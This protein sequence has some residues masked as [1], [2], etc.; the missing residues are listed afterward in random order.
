LEKKLYL[1][2]SKTFEKYSPFQKVKAM[3]IKKFQKQVEK[4]QE[5]KKNNG[6]ES[7]NGT[8]KPN[9]MSCCQKEGHQLG[10]QKFWK[11]NFLNSSTKCIYNIG[12]IVVFSILDI[13]YFKNIHILEIP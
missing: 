13:K 7:I 5:N 9:C 10:V 3:M 1:K 11:G 4:L 12:Y 6:K 8:P 2:K